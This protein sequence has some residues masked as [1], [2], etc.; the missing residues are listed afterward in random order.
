MARKCPKAKQSDNVTFSY[1]QA[2]VVS[3]PTKTR[4]FC[5]S[6][7]LDRKHYSLTR[8]ELE[9]Y[10]A[11][12]QIFPDAFVDVINRNLILC[13]KPIVSNILDHYDSE[14]G[15]SFQLYEVV[16]SYPT[17]LDGPCFVLSVGRRHARYEK[18]YNARL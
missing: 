6:S 12:S 16:Y 1:C 7:K 13:A 18:R 4:A 17:K 14:D 10:C 9:Q 2:P 11:Y 15:R 5:V 3:R 8:E